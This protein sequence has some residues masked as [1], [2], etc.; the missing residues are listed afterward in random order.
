MHVG[1]AVGL[2]S[3]TGA[4][5]ENFIRLKSGRL[6][7]TCSC[8]SGRFKGDRLIGRRQT[9]ERRCG[10]SFGHAESGHLEQIKGWPLLAS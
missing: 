5:L 6:V 9:D 1:A 10:M 3:P 8:V 2:I 7:L 4:D